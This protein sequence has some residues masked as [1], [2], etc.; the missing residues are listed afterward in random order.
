M[1]SHVINNPNNL[2]IK[3][4]CV[5]IPFGHRCSSAL[6]CK[7]ASIRNFSLPF[8]WTIPL[9]PNKIQKVL[10]NNFDDFIPDVYN[11]IFT[12]KYGFSLEHFNPNIN[13][14]VEDELI[15]LMIL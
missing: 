6:A 15:D 8:D 12:N 9:F 10:E 4:D 7:Y 5:V 13:M 14:G 2:V 1:F 11:G 3:N